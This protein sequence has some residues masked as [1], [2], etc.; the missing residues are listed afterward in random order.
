[1]PSSILKGVIP[2]PGRGSIDI[3][4]TPFVLRMFAKVEYVV[5]DTVSIKM[6]DVSVDTNVLIS[7]CGFAGVIVANML[8][9]DGSFGFWYTVEYNP[10]PHVLSRIRVLTGRGRDV[11]SVFGL[12]LYI[13]TF[14]LYD[15][16]GPIAVAP[17]AM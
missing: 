8:I 11:I 6:L 2:I 3:T 16:T 10:T 12:F 14:V 4:R 15:A 5:S 1:M 13:R 9:K 7:A 17:C